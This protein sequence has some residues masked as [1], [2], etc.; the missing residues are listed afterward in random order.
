MIPKEN[1]KQLITN[2][3]E[4]YSNCLN[5]NKFVDVDNLRSSCSD[6]SK[7]VGE[8]IIT[9]IYGSSK[10]PASPEQYRKVQS[11]AFGKKNK[12]SIFII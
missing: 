4:G 8:I 9:K 6:I 7:E 5:L 1:F 10:K 11:V 12:K 3:N 2:I